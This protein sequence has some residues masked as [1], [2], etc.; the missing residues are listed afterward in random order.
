MIFQKNGGPSK[1][2]NRGIKEATG[3]FIAFLDADD[4]WFPEKLELQYELHSENPELVWSCSGYKVV[5]GVREQTVY[6]ESS[7]F[8]RYNRFNCR[9]TFNLDEYCRD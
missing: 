5:G 2:R 9:W 1:A 6:F 3:Q 8:A 7:Y 4:E